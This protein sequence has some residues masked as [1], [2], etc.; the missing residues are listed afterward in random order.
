MTGCFLVVSFFVVRYS[1]NKSFS[2][3]SVLSVANNRRRF[4]RYS[5]SSAVSSFVP[6]WQKHPSS[7]VVLGSRYSLLTTR[8]CVHQYFSEIFLK[9]N[10]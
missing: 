6:S 9:W 7:P 8:Y 5:V 3:S 4:Q 10:P 1:N 2:V